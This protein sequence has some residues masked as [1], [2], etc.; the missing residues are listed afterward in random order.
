VESLKLIPLERLRVS[1]YNVRQ[2]VGEREIRELMESIANT[3]LHQPLVVMPSR[4]VPGT[5]EVVIGRRR[6]EALR[7]LRRERP[8]VFDKLFSDGVPCIVK[9]FTPKEAIIA[10]LTENLQRGEL[11]DEELGR[12]VYR[13]QVEYRM[14]LEEVAATVREDLSRLRRALE[15]LDAV[16]RGLGIRKPGR[17]P[18][19]ES[20]PKVSVS[21]ARAIRR[22][23]EE[24][25]AVKGLSQ[26]E[27]ESIKD[28]F[29]RAVAG[30]STRE[31]QLVARKAREEVRRSGRLPDV[32]SIVREV[33]GEK[34][35]ERVVL[36]SRR[37]IEGVKKLAE[38]RG[39]TFDEAL[40][41][42]VEA[43]LK[44]L[45]VL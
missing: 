7:R 25:A 4:E 2:R 18:R 32:E 29:Y 16:E 17:P 41:A 30:L 28:E 37:L 43:G 36:M 19:R 10:S 23:V 44:H 1:P 13:L 26:R 35:V 27:A 9:E 42:A 39:V 5:Y 45:G 21:A 14:S 3:G 8:E 20:E 22:V 24:V 15:A 12:A 11:S 38:E 31:I 33:R 6:L 34:R 40:E